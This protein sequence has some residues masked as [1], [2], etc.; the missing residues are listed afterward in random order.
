MFKGAGTPSNN[1]RVIPDQEHS[2]DEEPLV[3]LGVG[4]SAKVLA[5]CHCYRQN[6]EVV[7]INS[8]A[9]W[10]GHR[11]TTISRRHTHASMSSKGCW[12][13]SRKD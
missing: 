2:E 11:R 10:T 6:E 7:R 3:L 8:V 13:A 4:D 12:R 9:V 5:V 1:A